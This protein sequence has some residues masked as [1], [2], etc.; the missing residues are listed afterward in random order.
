MEKMIKSYV[1]KKEG[2]KYHFEELTF[3]DVVL[4]YGR[5]NTQEDKE[6]SNTSVPEIYDR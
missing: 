1:T 4:A 2:I 6:S 3:L 5:S